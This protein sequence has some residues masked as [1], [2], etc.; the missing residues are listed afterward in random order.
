MS[1]NHVFFFSLRISGFSRST[2]S[3]SVRNHSISLWI[4]LIPFD[5]KSLIG[6]FVH[7]LVDLFDLTLI[8]FYFSLFPWVGVEFGARMITIAGKQIKLQIWDTAGQVS[9]KNQ[10]FLLK[11]KDIITGLWKRELLKRHF[12]EFD[13]MRRYV[14]VCCSAIRS[15]LFR[16]DCRSVDG[17]IDWLIDWKIPWF[18][19]VFLFFL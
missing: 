12:F 14:H 15:R 4:F 7:N 3:Q 8:Y 10:I 1:E 11:F 16:W 18:F 19:W 6:F 2:I 9:R 17:L 13:N 5:S